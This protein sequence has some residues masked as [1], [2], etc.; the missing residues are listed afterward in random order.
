MQQLAGCMQLTPLPLEKAA[1][2][3]KSGHQSQQAIVRHQS[4]MAALEK[5]NY[6]AAVNQFDPLPLHYKIKQQVRKWVKKVK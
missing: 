1:Y 2:N 5:T 3:I 4:F 6:N